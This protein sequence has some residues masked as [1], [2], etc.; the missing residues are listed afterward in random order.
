MAGCEQR[1]LVAARANFGQPLNPLEPL[2]EKWRFTIDVFF[3]QHMV[4]FLQLSM[5]PT[6]TEHHFTCKC[7]TV[8]DSCTVLDMTFSGDESSHMGVSTVFH[9]F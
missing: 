5:Q 8:I 7:T 6:K 4:A 1:G 3:R 9:G 2:M